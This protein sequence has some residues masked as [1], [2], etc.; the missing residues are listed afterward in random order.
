MFS[1]RASRTEV[2]VVCDSLF[3]E[4][5]DPELVDPELVES[6]RIEKRN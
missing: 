5:V 1:L 3:L 4:L 2:R 6:N